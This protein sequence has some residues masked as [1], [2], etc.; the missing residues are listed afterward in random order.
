MELLIDMSD[1]IAKSAHADMKLPRHLLRRFPSKNVRII[2]LS[3]MT[4]LRG[5]TRSLR[6]WER[7]TYVFLSRKIVLFS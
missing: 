3:F 5:P 7:P 6:G 4:L 1:M 2:C